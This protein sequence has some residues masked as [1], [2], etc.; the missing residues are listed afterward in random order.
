MRACRALIFAWLWG[1]ML[2]SGQTAWAQAQVPIGNK[3]D[4]TTAGKLQ[5]SPAAPTAAP[6]RPATR[7]PARARTLKFDMSAADEMRLR[8]VRRPT[9]VPDS[10]AARRAVRELVL[11]L[12]AEA[13]LLASAD[14]L[15]WGRDTVRARLYVGEAFRW[16]YL[17]NGNLGDGLLTRAGYR[18]KFFRQAP[19]RPA[20][21]AALQERILTEAE[22]QGYP[23]ATVGLDSVRLRGRDIAGRVVL[24]RGPAI[25]FDSLEIVGSSRTRKEF[26][27]RYL[28]LVP[29]EPYSQQRVAAAGALLRQ[30]PYVR[31]RAEPEVRFARHRARV[32]LL[33]DE[34]PANQFDGIIGLLPN[35]AGAGGVQL[36]GDVTL[37]LRNLRGGGKQL[38]LQWRKTDAISQLLDAS[39]LH[40]S[41]FGT[42]LQVGATFN[43][44]R[45]NEAFLT[46]RPRLE[47]SYPTARAGRLAFFIEQR[48][49]RLL[50]TLLRQR[51]T[52]P[53]N[54]DTEFSAY[55][56][57]Y[58]RASLDDPYF[59]HRG[60]LLSVQGAVGSKVIRKNA[61]L[62]DSLYRRVALRS[63]Q[64]S[65]G[66]RVEYYRPLSRQTV[67]LVRLHG[68]GLL[69]PRFYLNDLF[70]LGGL[71]TLRGF[72]ENEFYTNAY[73]VGTVEL[74][75]F[76]GPEGYVFVFADQALLQAFAPLLQDR[77]R[78]LTGT[79]DAPGGLGAGLSFRTPAGLFQFAYSLGRSGF[80]NQPGFSL[81]RSKIHFGLTSRF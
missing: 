81:S 4:T 1:L 30:L 23:F 55:G 78:P 3:A 21:W 45:Q 70:R 72:N 8:R 42:P 68:E 34:R 60:L 25:Y 76:T 17:H 44:Y 18:E 36:T 74:R 7:L 66:G 48:S 54:L 63:T 16:A 56:L 35:A 49:S 2:S 46:L 20:E 51:T 52:L 14:T 58:A 69:N 32:Y 13:Y 40:P 79:R 57:G 19:W 33:L 59:P 77:G 39:Y 41:F 47:V 67:L 6:A 75:Q 71:N 53:A 62:N 26:L 24:R 29:G 31:L 61:G 73:G 65:F 22:N 38:G 80:L 12:Q 50:D 10:L 37:A 15:R 28:Q 43:L 27:A 5:P 11:A 9:T 64:Y